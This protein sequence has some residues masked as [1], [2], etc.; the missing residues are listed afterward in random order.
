MAEFIFSYR[1]AKGR[2]PVADGS[3]LGA[4]QAFLNDV[5]APNVVD[6]GWPVF[7]PYDEDD[8]RTRFQPRGCARPVTA[9]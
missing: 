9:G 7:E 1:S 2:E 6:P 8:D 5:V 4:W 3:E